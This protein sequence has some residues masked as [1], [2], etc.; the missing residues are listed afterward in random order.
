MIYY[1]NEKFVNYFQNENTVVQSEFISAKKSQLFR[2]GFLLYKFKL[3]YYFF[4]ALTTALNASG[5]FI[6]KSAR[7]L[8]FNSI[9]LLF[10]APMN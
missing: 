10:I 7:T 6:A 5:W 4:T 9:P 1:Q 3:L 8:R 2:I